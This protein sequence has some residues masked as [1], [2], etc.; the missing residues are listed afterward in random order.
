ML[1]P[2]DRTKVRV[3]IFRV[4]LII[5]MPLFVACKVNQ[6][7]NPV[8]STDQSIQLNDIWALE[9]INGEAV[10]QGDFGRE[11]PVLEFHKADG[12]VMGN[13]GCNRLSGSYKIEGNKI[14]FGPMISTKMACPGNGEQRFMT[15][16]NAVNTFRIE[17]LKLYLLNGDAEAL[18]FRKVD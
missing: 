14:T 16:L 15:A 11:I 6:S 2:K 3:F 1:K 9:E 12:K 8:A 10:T 4:A 18:Q 7:T 13:S 17:N 5:I